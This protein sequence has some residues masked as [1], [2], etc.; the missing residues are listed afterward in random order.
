MSPHSSSPLSLERGYVLHIAPM[1]Q[2]FHEDKT[3]GVPINRGV[4]DG[5]RRLPAQ[6]MWS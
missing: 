2:T 3:A 4:K 6:S 1:N 5:V